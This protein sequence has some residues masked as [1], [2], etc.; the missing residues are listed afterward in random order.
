MQRIVIV[1]RQPESRNNLVMLLRSM[2]PDCDVEV[3]EISANND[4]ENHGSLCFLPL[5]PQRMGRA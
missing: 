4:E 1:T 3:V 5:W 2:F